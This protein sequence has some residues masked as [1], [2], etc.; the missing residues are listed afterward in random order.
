MDLVVKG[1]NIDVT[2]SLRDYAQK[3][4]GRI[5]KNIQGVIETQVELSVIKN[6]SVPD[7]Q[8]AEV[9]LI[10]NGTV[11]RGVETT[12][13][14]YASIDLVSD[15]IE[16]QLRKYH[17]KLHAKNNRTKVS[18]VIMEEMASLETATEE[19]PFV[20]QI[21]R[22]KSFELKPMGPE[23]AAHQMEMLGHTFY[24]FLNQETNAVNV[25]YHRKDGNF[26]LIEPQ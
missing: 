3:K 19:A 11:I 7:N 1:K 4:L 16:R 21:V 15:K 10:A 24:L 14:M 18:E 20:P 6:K 22:L 9:T 5:T 8:I 12:D 17:D 2:D 26:G 25:V 13:N 23:E